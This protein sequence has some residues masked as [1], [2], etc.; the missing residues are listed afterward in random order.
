[1]TFG[2]VLEF[3]NLNCEFWVRF[4]LGNQI[5]HLTEYLFPP[6]KKSFPV[7][8]QFKASKKRR[9]YWN[10]NTKM[11][12]LKLPK[13]NVFFVFN[14][15]KPLFKK[16]FQNYFESYFGLSI[17][18]FYLFA[19]DIKLSFTIIFQR[20]HKAPPPPCVATE[21]LNWAVSFLF[22]RSRQKYKWPI[23]RSENA[24]MSKRF[25]W[26]EFQKDPRFVQMIPF[27]FVMTVETRKKIIFISLHFSKQNE[28]SF[29]S[30]L[31]LTELK[32]QNNSELRKGLKSWLIIKTRFT[33]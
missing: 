10:R 25:L 14:K 18:P 6:K 9:K 31:M 4:H 21:L 28:Y 26:K 20:R 3:K 2:L 29:C 30:S 1:M 11:I 13:N 17:F 8:F 24:D 23:K 19:E 5:N 22:T 15:F 33:K 7:E 12:K 27:Y 16:N 32:K